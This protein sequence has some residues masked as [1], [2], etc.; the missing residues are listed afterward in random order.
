MLSLVHSRGFSLTP[1]PNDTRTRQQLCRVRMVKIEGDNFMRTCYR[2]ACNSDVIEIP[3][4]I[5]TFQKRDQK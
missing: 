4:A 3:T 1:S 5:V 2:H